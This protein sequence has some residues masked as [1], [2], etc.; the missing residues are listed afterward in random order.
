MHSWIFSTA[1][2]SVPTNTSNTSPVYR[3]SNFT[4]VV[5]WES[6][7]SDG[8]VG[9]DNYTLTGAGITA[10]LTV[11]SNGPLMALATLSYNEMHMVSITASNCAGESTASVVTI[12]EGMIDIMISYRHTVSTCTMLSSVGCGPPTPP[13]RGSLEDLTSSQEGA[14]VTFQCSPGLVPSQQMMSV[15]AANGSWTPNP[16]ELTCVPSSPGRL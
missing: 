8:G 16:A 10:P 1:F 14:V 15:C 6:P 7:A 12:H 11:L 13:P 4:T 3:L 5:Q 9:I 2:P